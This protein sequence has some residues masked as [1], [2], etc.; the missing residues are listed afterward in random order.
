MTRYVTLG[1]PLTGGVEELS[2]AVDDELGKVAD[3][4]DHRLDLEV[5]SEVFKPQVGMLRF[6]E[7]ATFDPGRGTGLYLYLVDGWHHVAVAPA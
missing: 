3:A 6:F 4:I 1:L 5:S 7:A 2:R